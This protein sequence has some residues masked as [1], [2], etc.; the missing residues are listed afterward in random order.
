[1]SKM[2]DFPT[3]RPPAHS[4]AEALV[5]IQWR[6]REQEERRQRRIRNLKI[7]ATVFLGTLFIVC[8][9]GWVLF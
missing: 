4:Y 1:M 5:N 7:I 8:V 2:A 3:P 9:L 6:H